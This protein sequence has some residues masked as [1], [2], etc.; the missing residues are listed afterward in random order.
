MSRPDGSTGWIAEPDDGPNC[1][2]CGAGPGEFGHS[3]ELID[4]LH[5][6]CSPEYHS[7]VWSGSAEAGDEE[8]DNGQE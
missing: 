7:S 3:R 8:T 1:K 2:W 6:E 4:E 5:P